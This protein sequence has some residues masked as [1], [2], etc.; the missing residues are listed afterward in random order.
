MDFSQR[1]IKLEIPLK[2]ANTRLEIVQGNN[3]D[4]GIRN[5]DTED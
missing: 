2:K 3:M 4:Q 5:R 1:G